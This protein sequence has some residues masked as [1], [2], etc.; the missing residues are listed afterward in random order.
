[1]V[2][3]RT[4]QRQCLGHNKPLGHHTNCSPVGL[5][6][7]NSLGEY[8]DLSTVSEVFL[9]LV[10]PVLCVRLIRLLKIVT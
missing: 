2:R 9:I 7:Y 8:G 1:M 4:T 6:Q 10:I 5:G 3:I